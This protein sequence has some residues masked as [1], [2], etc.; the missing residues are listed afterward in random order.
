MGK[1]TTKGLKPSERNLTTE[2]KGK[3]T[4][5]QWQNTPQQNLFMEL[6]LDVSKP[7]FGNAYQSA[8][9]AGYSD[10]YAQQL[11]APSVNNKW[12]TEYTKGT[13]MDAEHTKK[14]LQDMYLNPASYNNSRSP[15]DTR[16][17]T[18]ELMLKVN[19]QID[20]KG[21][22]NFTVVQPILGGKSVQGNKKVKAEFKVRDDTRTEELIPED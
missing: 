2:S 12:I 16:V 14:A 5:N 8:I 15:A 21:S 6:W 3:L 11:A 9:Q 19:G 18:L 10:Y 7:T 1:R 13:V 17:K 4:A 22:I 20:N